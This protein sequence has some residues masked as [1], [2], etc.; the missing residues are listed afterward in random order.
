MAELKTRSLAVC[1]E[2]T[3][4]DALQ[5]MINEQQI[6]ASGYLRKLLLLDLIRTGKLSDGDILK[7]MTS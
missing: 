5:N 3:L 4:Y 2:Q 6:S 7:I 1:I